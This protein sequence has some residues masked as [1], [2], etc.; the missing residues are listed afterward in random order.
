[1]RNLYLKK[2]GLLNE[3]NFSKLFKIKQQYV[4]KWF[5]ND[6]NYWPSEFIV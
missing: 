1:M 2:T 6:F 3:N 5:N 4:F